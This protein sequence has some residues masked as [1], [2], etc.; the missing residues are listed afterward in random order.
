MNFDRVDSEEQIFAEIAGLRLFREVGVGCG[1]NAHIDA[2]CLRRADALEFAGFKHAQQFGLLAK[3]DVGNFV[4][5]ERTAVG[6]FEAADAIGAR[7][8]ECAFYVAEYLAFE[9]SFGKPAGV[10]GDE[11]HAAAGRRG[12]QK[13]GDDLLAG[14]VLA[15][16]EHVGVGR[17]DLRR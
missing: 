1:E 6:Q 4:E 13:L 3:R 14:A 2:A 9:G 17:A 15:G 11:R 7:I 10:D 8:G 16:D 5:K 12:M